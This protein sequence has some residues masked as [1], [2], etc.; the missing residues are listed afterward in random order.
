MRLYH[1]SPMQEGDAQDETIHESIAL[2]DTGRQWT[3]VPLSAEAPEPGAG[4]VVIL[5]VP[6]DIVGPFE[7]APG[8]FVVPV[9]VIRP[10]PA[11][12]TRSEP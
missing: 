10:Y 7:V 1:W 6:R 9:G 5:D 2:H 3:G 8:R 11:V 12:P 4:L